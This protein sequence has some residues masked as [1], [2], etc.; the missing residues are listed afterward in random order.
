MTA[1]RKPNANTPDT[2]R[3]RRAAQR[4]ER[5]GQR[6]APRKGAQPAWRSPIALMTGAALLVGIVVIAFAFVSKPAGPASPSGGLIAPTTTIPTELVDG[7]SMGYAE[8]PVTLD[9]WAD[10]QCPYC[11]QVARLI[12]PALIDQY[13]VPGYVRLVFHDLAFLGQSSSS[14]WDES[15]EAA[16][17]ARCAA[18]QGL[19]WQMHDWLFANQAGE[20]AGG[21]AEDRLRSIAEAAGLDMGAYDSCMAAGDK[22]ASVESD[23]SD[24]FAAGIHSTPTIKLNGSLYTGRLTLPDIEGAISAAVGS[25]TPAPNAPARSTS[26][27]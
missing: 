4:S 10:F 5:S 24:E 15:V 6:N 11:G 8:A 25:A 22:Q 1:N 18:D 14:G 9:I 21:F 3:E 16:S 19:F 12:E 2:R 17:A 13:V 23:T 26:A 7:R 27:P 20:N